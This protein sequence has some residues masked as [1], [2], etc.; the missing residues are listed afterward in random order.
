MTAGPAA[1]SGLAL[2]TP[3]DWF[4]IRL[5]HERADANRLMD[6][7]LAGRPDLARHRDSLRDLLIGLIDAAETLAVAAA[8]ATVLDVVGG[9]LVATLVVTVL[10]IGE[11][12]LDAIA[13]ELGAQRSDGLP[14]TVVGMFDLP[15][16][17]TA[18]IERLTESP[19]IGDRRLVSLI[20]Q[21]VTEAPAGQA[22]MLTFSTPAVALADQLRPL[23]HQIACTLRFEMPE[24]ES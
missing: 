7:V 24:A 4:A 8:Y 20:A 18:R 23:F 15:A 10:P 21:Y 16:G 9:P 22:V 5:P 2:A 1:Y 17:R 3:G 19:D 11:H 14:P 12:S 13:A 6:D